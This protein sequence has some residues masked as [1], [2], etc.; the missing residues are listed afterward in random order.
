MRTLRLR[1]VRPFSKSIDAGDAGQPPLRSDRREDIETALAL[2]VQHRPVM[3]LAV[4][5]LPE[6]VVGAIAVEPSAQCAQRL[7]ATAV[8]ASPATYV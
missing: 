5:V 8:K 6:E 2:A 1:R 7:A 3:H 4:G